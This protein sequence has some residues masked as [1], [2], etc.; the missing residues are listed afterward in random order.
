MAAVGF[1]TPDVWCG[2]FYEL[3]VEMGRR[4]NERLCAALEVLWSH[5][6][7]RRCY[8]RRDIE[9]QD[10]IPVSPADV[11]LDSGRHLYGWAHLPDGHVTVCG[12]VIVREADS[13]IDWLSFYLPTAALDV[14]FD[15]GDVPFEHSS[16]RT[17]HALVEAWLA[18][19][20]RQ[21]YARVPYR[22]GLIG[23]EVSG[24]DYAINLSELGIP[25]KRSI[26]YLWPGDGEVSFFPANP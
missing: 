22:M 23:Y 14:V 18:V 17:L 19:L 15:M 3:A 2:G 12:T 4:S 26:G 9:P 10:Q 20:G 24:L 1:I 25:G 6:S 11:P 13:G 5:P 8:L 7:I 21:L 16:N